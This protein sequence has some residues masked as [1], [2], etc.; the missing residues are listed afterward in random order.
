ML[1]HCGT[2]R[3]RYCRLSFASGAFVGV[4]VTCQTSGVAK[5]AMAYQTLRTIST[6]GACFFFADGPAGVS[7]DDRLAVLVGEEFFAVLRDRKAEVPSKVQGKS[8]QQVD[9]VK[10][11][12]ASATVAGV[13]VCLVA[14]LS[15]EDGTYGW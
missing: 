13:W 2:E 12:S 14:E 3:L 15:A 11:F 5:S 4:H 6:L 7:V 8:G 10:H 9:L 1:L